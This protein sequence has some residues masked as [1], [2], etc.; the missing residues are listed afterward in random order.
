MLQKFKNGTNGQNFSLGTVNYQKLMK[1][2]VYLRYLIRQI[3]L[4]FYLRK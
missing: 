2:N 4:I 3:P 1:T